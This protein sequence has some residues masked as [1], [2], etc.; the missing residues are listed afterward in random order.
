MT[1][2]NLAAKVVVV[3]A[4]L[5]GVAGPAVPASAGGA[6]NVVVAQN[7]TDGNAFARSGVMV[8][9]NPSDSVTNA[10]LAIANGHD[11]TGCRTVSVAMQVV[12]VESYPSD[13]EPQNA[14]SAANGGCDGCQTYAFAY[15]YVIQPATMVNLSG[16]AQQGIAQI[17]QEVSDV[18]QSGADYADMQAQLD[19]L[20]NDLAGIVSGDL[21]INDAPPCASDGQEAA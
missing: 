13:Y 10:N 2:R 7:T 16:D 6:D 20:C 12:I 11:C 1:K 19:G 3:L 9:Y 21:G 14:A 4:C 15:Q 5:V 17:R 8:A 18:A